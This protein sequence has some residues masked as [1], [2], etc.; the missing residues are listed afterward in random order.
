M[1]TLHGIKLSA[2]E[3]SPPPPSTSGQTN[4]TKEEEMR[5]CNEIRTDGEDCDDCDD[6]GE[7]EQQG[8][9]SSSS[10]ISSELNHGVDVAIVN[11]SITKAGEAEKTTN[12][13]KVNVTSDKAESD[14]GETMK[15]KEEKKENQAL[16]TSRPCHL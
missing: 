7:S 9:S 4:Q 6:V 16:G 5:K 10:S 1:D 8:G 12:M 14:K 3:P 11:G 2:K 13:A 15:V